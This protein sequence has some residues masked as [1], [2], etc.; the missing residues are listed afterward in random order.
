MPDAAPL[1]GVPYHAADTYLAKLVDAGFKVAVCEQVEDPKK[2]KGIVRR[3]VTRV[4][5]PGTA[6]S[7]GRLPAKQNR[8]MTAIC[9]EGLIDTEK[10]Q[11]KLTYFD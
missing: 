5:T 7:P 1:C 4:I 8:F 6:I 2:A 9:T 10:V 11:D 3:A